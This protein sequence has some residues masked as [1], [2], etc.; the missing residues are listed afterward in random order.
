MA[1]GV[2]AR[3]NQER[4]FGSITDSETKEEIFVHQSQ[5]VAAGYRYLLPKEPVEYETRYN[6]EKQRTEAV[7][8]R[9]A[10]GR[11]RGTVADFVHQKGFG[12]ITPEAGGENV[13][14]H[15]SEILSNGR[16]RTTAEKGEAVE[17]SLSEGQGG[18]KASATLVKRNDSRAPLF[19]FAQMGRDES[20]LRKLASKVEPERWTFD[21]SDG[22]EEFPILKSYLQ[23]TFERLEFEDASAPGTKIAVGRDGRSPVACFNT[24][25]VTPNQEEVYVLFSAN[26]RALDNKWALEGFYAPSDHKMIGKFEKFPELANYFDDPGVLLYDRRLAL[27]LDFDHILDDNLNRFPDSLRQNKYQA[28]Q[29][30]IAAQE[31]TQKRVY[32]NYKSAVP[33]YYRGNIQL[34]LPLS[35]EDPSRADL[36]LVVSSVGE[37]TTAAYLGSTVLTLEMAYNNARLLCRPASDWLEPRPH[38]QHQTD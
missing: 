5:I 17:Y 9:S 14:F 23:Y 35:L 4:G 20:W 16:N 27:H 28:R 21:S 2:V 31:L 32:R 6:A 29:A 24:G 13:F 22:D 15:H 18:K 36:A 10:P 8:V 19:R 34:L 7:A 33:Q 11:Q 3:Y 12:F 38:G 30:L 1:T 37:G 26:A 25:L